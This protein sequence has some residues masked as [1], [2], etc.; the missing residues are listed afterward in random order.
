[1]P[2]DTPEQ[3]ERRRDLMARIQAIQTPGVPSGL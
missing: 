1:M 2:T 3:R